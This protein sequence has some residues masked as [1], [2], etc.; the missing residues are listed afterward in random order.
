MFFSRDSLVVVELVDIRTLLNRVL[1][2]LPVLTSMSLSFPLS[3]FLSL[4]LQREK[5]EWMESRWKR[6]R[7]QVIDIFPFL[8][9]IGE[10]LVVVGFKCM[11]DCWGEN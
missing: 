6:E 1:P 5:R 7:E 8:G 11:R 4:S 2:E 3:L 9:K 10:D